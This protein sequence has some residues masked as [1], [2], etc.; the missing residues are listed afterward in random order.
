M[1]RL[2]QALAALQERDP[3]QRLAALAVLAELSDPDALPALV[4][5]MQR[6]SDRRVRAASAQLSRQLSAR[7]AASPRDPFAQFRI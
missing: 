2:E 6:D 3:E 5:C 1:S 7:L 4:T